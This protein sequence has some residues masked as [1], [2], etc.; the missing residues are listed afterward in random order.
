MKF[1]RTYLTNYVNKK[2]DTVKDQEK[3]LKAIKKMDNAYYEIIRLINE[4]K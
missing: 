1:W 2:F 3:F 4:S